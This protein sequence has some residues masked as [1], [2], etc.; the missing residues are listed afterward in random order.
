MTKAAH[1]GEVKLGLQ[2]QL[3]MK[4]EFVVNTQAT[5]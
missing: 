5:R 3:K 2:E 4:F 1:F